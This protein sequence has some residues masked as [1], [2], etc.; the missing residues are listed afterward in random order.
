MTSERSLHGELL[1]EGQGK[2]PY[3]GAREGRI[4]KVDQRRPEPEA[5]VGLLHQPLNL[6]RRGDPHGRRD[7]DAEQARDL[8]RLEPA[9]MAPE[10]LERAAGVPQVGDDVALKGG[11][12]PWLDGRL[13]HGIGESGARDPPGKAGGA[14]RRGIF[15]L[16]RILFTYELQVH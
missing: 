5:P 3:V 16:P 4:A 14:E 11:I 8:R 6:E 2:L 15:L 12:G 13:A 7:R 1:E 10:E 9:G